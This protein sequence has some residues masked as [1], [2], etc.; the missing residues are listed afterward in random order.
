[1][2]TEVR[3]YIDMTVI[4]N[5]HVSYVRRV[6]LKTNYKLHVQGGVRLVNLVIS[7]FLQCTIFRV[8]G[9]RLKFRYSYDL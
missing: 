2:Q 1:M 8:L 3:L 9:K 7:Y 6:Y 4:T 5:K